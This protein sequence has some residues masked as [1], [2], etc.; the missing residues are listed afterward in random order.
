MSLKWNN[1]IDFFKTTIYYFDFNYFRMNPLVIH[2]PKTN[3]R[4]QIDHPIIL[5]LN[6]I[7]FYPIHLSF[8]G[9]TART[10]T[11][12]VRRNPRERW[13]PLR[14]CYFWGLVFN[15]FFTF[16]NSICSI[17]VLLW[18]SDNKE[19][20]NQLF[21]NKQYSIEWNYYI[22]G[23]SEHWYFWA[24]QV[25]NMNYSNFFFFIFENKNC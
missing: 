13:Y 15:F 25:K 22:F 3:P 11:K 6:H 17:L 18:D 21:E 2:D 14:L 5:T 1:S 23:T 4:R 9:C 8:K 19:I 7:R 10:I 16:Q 24:I 20:E 12:D